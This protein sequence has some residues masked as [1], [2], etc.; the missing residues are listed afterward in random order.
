MRKND[1]GSAER[2]DDGEG[3]AQ[4][5]R[6]RPPVSRDDSREGERDDEEPEVDRRRERLV[7]ETLRL[8]RIDPEQPRRRKH[9]RPEALERERPEQRLALGESAGSGRGRDPRPRG[10][11][12]DRRE[13]RPD[14]ERDADQADGARA[15]EDPPHGSPRG[16]APPARRRDEDEHRSKT[17]KNFGTTRQEREP[18]ARSRERDPAPLDGAVARRQPLDQKRHRE[19]CPGGSG[20]QVR[21]TVEREDGTR[22]HGPHDRQR[23]RA[24]ARPERSRQPRRSQP[25][26]RAVEQED[27]LEPEVVGQHGVEEPRRVKAPRQRIRGQRHAQAS[28]GIA[29]RRHQRARARGVRDDLAERIEEVKEVAPRQLLRRVERRGV[30]HEAEREGEERE[31]GAGAHV[32]ESLP[33]LRAARS[34]GLRRGSSAGAGTSRRAERARPRASPGS[35]RA[36][37]GLAA[38]EPLASRRRGAAA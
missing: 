29:R 4:P 16:V 23:A 6:A 33:E 22:E 24:R 11:Q 10:R 37:A 25:R 35:R 21:V 7:A 3:R 34:G 14:P 5:E 30:S 27:E 19:G 9:E 26:E 8:A 15:E 31:S 32:R 2:E 13:Q 28:R 12:L 20:Q 1:P 18:D 38:P 17:E 36:C